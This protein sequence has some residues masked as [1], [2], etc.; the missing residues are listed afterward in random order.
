MSGKRW[1]TGLARHA[2][3]KPAR[4]L[5]VIAAVSFAT[6]LRLTPVSVMCTVVPG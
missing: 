5:V 3:V 1:V 6:Y 4:W 2:E